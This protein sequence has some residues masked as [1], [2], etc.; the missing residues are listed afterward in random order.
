MPF[1]LIQNVPQKTQ[2]ILLT[3]VVLCCSSPMQRLRE[4]LIIS[5]AF[6]KSLPLY[7]T[8]KNNKKILLYFVNTNSASQVG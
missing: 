6:T 3:A 7:R 5:K 2:N 1:S 8:L 4:A